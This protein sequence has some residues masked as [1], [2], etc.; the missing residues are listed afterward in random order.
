M[1]LQVGD[2]IPDFSTRV[3]GSTFDSKSVVGVQLLFLSK[4][5][6]SQCTAQACSL[7]I[8][9]RILK[10]RCRV[11]GISSDGSSLKKFKQQYKLPF[12]LLSDEN[13]KIQKFLVYQRLIWYFT[14]QSN[15]RR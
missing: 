5:N 7:E 13:K 14:R 2:K 1:A 10:I 15:L 12:I 8:N 4:D 9:M 3:D 6:T 11:I